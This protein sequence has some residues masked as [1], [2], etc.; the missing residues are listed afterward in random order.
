MPV[1]L[2]TRS[3]F[4][5]ILSDLEDFWD[6]RRTECLHHPIFFYEFGNTAYVIKENGVVLAYLFGFLSQTQPCAYVHL[7]AVRKG[8]RGKGL[9]RSLYDHFTAYARS[10]DCREIKAITGLDNKVSLAFHTELGMKASVV[11]D[12]SGLGKDNI[13][14]N[15]AL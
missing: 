1:S 7:I 14:F 8:C 6:S 2:C 11:K 10:R 12:Y 9:G 15:K 4:D 5:Q 3:D 13:V